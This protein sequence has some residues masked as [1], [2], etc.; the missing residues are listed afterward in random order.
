MRL[1]ENAFLC[2]STCY[3]TLTSTQHHVHHDVL[4]ADVIWLVCL[5][6]GATF[7]LNIMRTK[8]VAYLDET[9]GKA[10]EEATAAAQKAQ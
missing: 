10:A 1:N 2:T 7:I 3:C 4:E 8:C 5:L 6:S 9:R